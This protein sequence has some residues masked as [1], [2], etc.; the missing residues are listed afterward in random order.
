MLD[1]RQI[2]YSRFPEGGRP[3]GILSFPWSVP[4]ML[5]QLIVQK[6]LERRCVTINGLHVEYHTTGML[7]NLTDLELIT[8]RS[9]RLIEEL[10]R[11]GSSLGSKQF[12]TLYVA[13]Q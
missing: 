6:R 7:V 12:C 1:C 10:V 9:I 13:N 4:R 3:N 11:C 8:A 2:G 5:T